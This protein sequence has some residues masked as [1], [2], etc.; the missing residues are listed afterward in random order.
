MYDIVIDH[1]QEVLDGKEPP[2]FFVQV[3]GRGGIGKSFTIMMISAHLQ[4][5]ARSN[6]RPIPM[7][8]AAPTG[9]AAHG[10]AGRTL[11]WLLRLLFRAWAELSAANRTAMRQQLAN[12]PYLIIDENSMIE[13][14]SGLFGPVQ[15]STTRIC[16]L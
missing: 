2:Q 4:R 8:I 9:I 3:D 14:M 11:H 12:T 16:Y 6:D 5:M 7:K 10:I 15:I 13:S 1:H